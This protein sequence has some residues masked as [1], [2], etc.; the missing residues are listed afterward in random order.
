MNVP[1]N[2]IFKIPG[3]I[4]AWTRPLR[5]HYHQG[6]HVLLSPGKKVGWIGI[7]SY[8]KELRVQGSRQ[9]LM[10]TLYKISCLSGFLARWYS[11]RAPVTPW[12]QILLKFQYFL[13]QYIHDVWN[14][15]KFGLPVVSIPAP[16]ASIAIMV[17]TIESFPHLAGM[18]IEPK[19]YNLMGWEPSNK[20]CQ[21]SVVIGVVHIHLL[22]CL[23]HL[24]VIHFALLWAYILCFGICK[25]FDVFLPVCNFKWCNHLFHH[26]LPAWKPL[27]SLKVKHGDAIQSY[28]WKYHHWIMMINNNNNNKIVINLQGQEE[29]RQ[30]PAQ[31][32]SLSFNQPPSIFVPSK[33]PFLS[34]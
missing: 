3:D 26:I 1:T 20:L 17:G 33:C 8:L 23:R 21:H 24:P 11:N 28:E 16:R 14:L 27:T 5:T 15:K 13:N 9:F 18:N 30:R 29:H 12:I 34:N 7:W 22:Q 25:L 6:Q 32:L 2:I 10:A 19:T 31:D 4:L